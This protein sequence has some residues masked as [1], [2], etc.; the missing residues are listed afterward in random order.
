MAERV[1]AADLERAAET[2]T[3]TLHEYG[4]MHADARVV[5][6]GAYGRTYAYV[7]GGP[8]Y[9][10]GAEDLTR[11]GTKREVQAELRAI[12]RAVSLGRTSHGRWPRLESPAVI[13]PESDQHYRAGYGWVTR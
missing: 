10:S 3:E 9:G 4:L 5:I 7:T 8:H 1:A 6:G 13:R 11:H 12:T 2:V